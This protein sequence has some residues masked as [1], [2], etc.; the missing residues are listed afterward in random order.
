MSAQDQV[1]IRSLLTASEAQISSQIQDLTPEERKKLSELLKKVTATS[2]LPSPQ[3]NGRRAVVER[4]TSETEIRA[5]IDLDGTGSK[6]QVSTGIGFLDHMFHALA[7]HGRF[8]LTLHCKGDLHIDDHHS[9]EDCALALGEAFD[10]ALGA[11]KGI[12]RYGSAHAPLDEAL[13]LAVVDIS[14]RPFATLE[15]NLQR[16]KVGELSC[17]MVP[18]VLRSFAMAARITL[19]LQVVR[20][21]NDHH[22]IESA[23]KALALALRQAIT[24][25]TQ[26]LDVVPSTKGVLA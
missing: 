7:K 17:E 8:D 12:N 25:D 1:S 15:L 13:S 24:V 21:E 11:R 16:E 19:H 2:D 26:R 20:G 23:F 22:R 14:S 4:L 5:E 6:I 18:H 10:K 3:P 9:A